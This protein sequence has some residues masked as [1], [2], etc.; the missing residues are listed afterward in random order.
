MMNLLPAQ[1]ERVSPW[2]P[3]QKAVLMLTVLL[4]SGCGIY[5]PYESV[6][7]GPRAKVTIMKNNP[8][9]KLDVVIFEPDDN[10]KLQFM[11]R[12]ML[13]KEELARTIFMPAKRAYFRVSG[14]QLGYHAPNLQDVS[15]LLEEN[16]A[17][18]IEFEWK[19]ATTNWLGVTKGQFEMKYLQVSVGSQPKTVEVDHFSVCTREKPVTKS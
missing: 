2:R 19:G 15:F 16:Q 7:S 8:A 4:L 3:M 10:C 18:S 1:N 6:Q 17:Y 14:Q 12:V 11:G 5:K 13:E 9:A